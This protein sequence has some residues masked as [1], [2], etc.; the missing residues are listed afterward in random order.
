[1][2]S[3]GELSGNPRG[4]ALGPA[5]ALLYVAEAGCGGSTGTVG[6][7]PQAPPPLGLFLGGWSGRVSAITPW[8]TRLTVLDGLPFSQT[9]LGD[10]EGPTD[11]DFAGGVLRV[12]I[13]AGWSKA[14]RSYPVGSTG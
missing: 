10:A 1:M 2:A 6:P 9:Q 12:L 5:G 4:L 14:T 11:V 7:C 8:G 13:Q 3:R